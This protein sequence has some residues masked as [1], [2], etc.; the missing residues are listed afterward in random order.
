MR[1]YGNGVPVARGKKEWVWLFKS[2]GFRYIIIF[3][4]NQ[5]REE[6]RIR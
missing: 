6:E 5:K 4:E 2:L 1:Y 3:I